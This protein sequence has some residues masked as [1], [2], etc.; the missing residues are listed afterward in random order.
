MTKPTSSTSRSSATMRTQ[1]PAC[2]RAAVT[3]AG[4]AAGA[5]P[6]A[7]PGDTLGAGPGVGLGSGPGPGPGPGMGPDA[8]L[9][10]AVA[11]AGELLYGA[12][13]DVAALAAALALTPSC[14]AV[15]RSRAARIN[16]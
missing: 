9:A 8:E 3:V 15:C 14:F 12:P 5:G 13:L 11:P 4:R 10:P 16:V 2:G 7:G 1:N 6:G